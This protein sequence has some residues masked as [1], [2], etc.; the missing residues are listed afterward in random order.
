MTK[1]H[2]MTHFLGRV[3]AV[4]LGVMTLMGA[5]NA[6]LRYLGSY[7]G[8]TLTSNAFL[9]GQWFLFG[10]VFL[11]GAGYVFQSDTHVRVDVFY[12]RLSPSSKRKINVL[13]TIFFL[14]P[15]CIFGVWSSWDYTLVSIRQ[16]EM[17]RDAGGLPQYPVKMLIPLSFALLLLQGIA[18]TWWPEKES[19]SP[20][21]EGAGD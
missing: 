1:I 17:S 7:I 11:L 12:G 21:M 10:A 19:I 3:C 16:L 2:A 18:S 9:E 6:L 15:F 14:I 8:K 5:G 13:G 20:T 4:L